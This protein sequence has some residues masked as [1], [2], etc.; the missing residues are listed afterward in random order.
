MSCDSWF[1]SQCYMTIAQSYELLVGLTASH[2]AAVVLFKKIY[3]KG[4]NAQGGA[5]QVMMK[6]SPCV[7]HS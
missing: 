6:Q 5:S 7:E 2:T 1:L 4:H 3:K